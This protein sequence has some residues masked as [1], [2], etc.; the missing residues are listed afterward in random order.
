MM[1]M[2]QQLKQGGQGAST[3]SGNQHG[4]GGSALVHHHTRDGSAP[5]DRQMLEFINSKQGNL[6]SGAVTNESG[7]KKVSGVSTPQPLGGVFN[8]KKK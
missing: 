4:T 8:K 5:L 2:M 6:L 7:F 1:M 3:V